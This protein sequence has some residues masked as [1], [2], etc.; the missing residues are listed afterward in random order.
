MNPYKGLVRVND[1]QSAMEAYEIFK[2]KNKD[3]ADMWHRFAMLMRN[4]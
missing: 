4:K 2:D 3:R 1:Y